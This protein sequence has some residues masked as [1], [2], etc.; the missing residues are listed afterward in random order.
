MDGKEI[1]SKVRTINDAWAVDA[2]GR[3]QANNFDLIR[4]FAA[5]LV[6]FSHSFE[7]TDGSRVREPLEVLSGQISLGE[8]AV[9]VFFAVSGFLITKSWLATPQVSVFAVKR[10]LRIMPALVVAVL[11]LAF[12]IGPILT[13]MTLGEYFSGAEL[14]GFVRHIFFDSGHQDLPGVFED[15]P[16]AKVV[17]APLWT[18]FYEAFF[19]AIILVLGAFGLLRERICT[20]FFVFFLFIL[21]A[22]S[23]GWA[24]AIVAILAAPFF[25]GATAALAGNYIPLDG[26]L[27]VIS[28]LCLIVTA[29]FGGLVIGFAIFGVY[30]VLYLGFARLGPQFGLVKHATRFGDIS[31][32]LYIWGW[33]VQQIVQ[34]IVQ[35]N[36]AGYFD[37]WAVN[38]AISFP[39]TC[40]IAYA[41]WRLVEQPS[42][43]MKRH[44]LPNAPRKIPASV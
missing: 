13:T 40:I 1:E 11:I 9:L 29:A 26:R 32:G 25:A 8:F 35:Q 14:W 36:T 20:A 42:L 43:A 28:A 31:Y 5:A 16:V 24:S 18:L 37:G 23:L 3:A 7:I 41:S 21:M 10:G 33:P 44:F 2:D 4:L 12:V 27:A 19:Y 6:I 15:A 30:L 39:V 17:N 34:Q 22:P 38:F